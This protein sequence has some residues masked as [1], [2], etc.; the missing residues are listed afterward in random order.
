M[1]NFK[2]LILDVGIFRAVQ[3]EYVFS[4]Q[5]EKTTVAVGTLSDSPA[6]TK[7]TTNDNIT[8]TNPFFSTRRSGF[9]F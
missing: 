7:Q 9:L 5:E 4:T 8:K 1:T 3:S 2:I 6:V